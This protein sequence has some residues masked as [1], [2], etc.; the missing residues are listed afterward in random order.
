MGQNRRK[1]LLLQRWQ[2]CLDG[3]L[4]AQ[5]SKRDAACDAF[6]SVFAKTFAVGAEE[7]QWLHDCIWKGQGQG[8]GNDRLLA[9]SQLLDDFYAAGWPTSLI[10]RE[11]RVWVTFS[12]VCAVST[13]GTDVIASL[14]NTDELA[15]AL[16]GRL[17]LPAKDS[18][19]VDAHPFEWCPHD[20][21]RDLNIRVARARGGLSEPSALSGNFRFSEG[22]AEGVVRTVLVTASLDRDEAQQPDLLDKMAAA[23]EGLCA[24]A[25]Y[26]LMSLGPHPAVTQTA[27]LR[28]LDIGWPYST[29]RRHAF[30]EGL[31]S[32]RSLFERLQASDCEPTHAA[33]VV[34]EQE[35][36]PLP[37]GVVGQDP[38]ALT[39]DP[40]VLCLLGSAGEPAQAV[41][42]FY[43]GPHVVGARAEAVRWL[44][45]RGLA[46][47]DAQAS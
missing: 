18:V 15:H 32:L 13:P 24:P 31:L 14:H 43:E 38:D 11:G 34:R 19:Q 41:S 2:H 8:K 42:L 28:V 6:Y 5:A 1:Q 9:M 12:L 20:S 30:T 45:E 4:D 21:L 44:L 25:S 26:R 37:A 27:H 36:E 23:I 3:V 35:Q 33:V 39:L 7:A 10:Q 16:A 40:V 47:S 22:A 17:G 46:V 29:G